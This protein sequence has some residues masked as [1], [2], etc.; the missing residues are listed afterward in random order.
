[1]QIN[2]QFLRVKKKKLETSIIDGAIVVVD[3]VKVGRAMAAGTKD[4]R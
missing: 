1:M 3:S 2:I 4:C